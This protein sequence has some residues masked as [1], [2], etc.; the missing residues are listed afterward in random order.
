MKWLRLPLLPFSAVVWCFVALRNLFFDKGIL[1]VARCPVPVLSIGNISVGGVGKTPIVELFV[2]ALIEY[3]RVAVVSRGYKRRSRGT[4]VV[5][6][7]RNICVPVYDAGDEPYQL[8]QKFPSLIVVVDEQRERGIA[9]ALE[10]GATCIVLDDAFQHRSVA[11]DIDLVVL[12]AD[13]RESIEFLLP[14]GNRREPLSSLHRCNVIVLSRCRNEE[15]FNRAS[16]ALKEYG[17]P[18]I[19]VTTNI[20]KIVKVPTWEHCDVGVIV[21]RRVLLVSGIGNPSDFEQTMRSLNVDIIDH[22]QYKDHHWYSKYDMT[23]IQHCAKKKNADIICTTE[24][25][26]VRMKA[27]VS[28][29]PTVP[30]FSILIQQ[31]IIA[32]E[33]VVET[34]IQKLRQNTR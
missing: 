22:L 9:R 28:E 33:N 21:G 19:G 24:K 5:S 25:D 1:R 26:A 23:N 15:H 16:K 20:E 13:E 8:A 3:Q 34:I 32:G 18:C 7:G 6:D 2:R 31:R 4:I 11:R 30:M 27:V 14:A 10:L 17:K 12:S 29:I